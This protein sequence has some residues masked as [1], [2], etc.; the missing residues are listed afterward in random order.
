[1][2]S[3]LD[4]DAAASAGERERVDTLWLLR[5][6]R[7]EMRCL[8]GQVIGRACPLNPAEIPGVVGK[9]LCDLNDEIARLES[10]EVDAARA[11][12]GGAKA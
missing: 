3:P 2:T 12:K 9:V 6:V 8:Y 4:A 5:R 11:A 7:V 10:R 1:M